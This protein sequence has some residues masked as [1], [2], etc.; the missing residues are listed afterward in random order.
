MS[1][2]ALILLNPTAGQR[3]AGAWRQALE[4]AFGDWPG[5]WSIRE[6]HAIGDAER[7]AAEV[8][9]DACDLIVAAGG[10]G[11]INEVVNGLKADVALGILPL[12]TANV[13]ALELGISVNDLPAALAVIRD[14]EPRP[15]DLGRINNRRFLLMAGFGFDAE[16]VASVAKP[17]KDLVGGPAY[18]LSAVEAFSRVR[19]ARFRLQADT[20][21]METQAYMVVVANAASYAGQLQIAPL[22]TIDDGWLD[23]CV[24]QERRPGGFLRQAWQVLRRRHL[25]DPD[26][27]YFRCRSIRVEAT[28]E[29][30][31]QVDGD[32]AGR[33]PARIEL[34][35]GAVR[36]YR[37]S[38]VGTTDGHR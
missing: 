22:A 21:A 29:V 38:G 35:P 6:T 23:V 34:L 4:H 10:D 17:L 2:R 14:G 33:T 7:M 16:V 28:P 30:G 3:R 25:R 11:T 26:V 24:F 8:N 19:P 32:P 37:P 1:R 9:D 5:S 27:R 13:L 36:V 15:I 18:F 20:E 31:I 12:G